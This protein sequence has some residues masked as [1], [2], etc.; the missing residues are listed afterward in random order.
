MKVKI[1]W[2]VFVS[3]LLTGCD[4]YSAPLSDIHANKNASMNPLTDINARLA[5][6]CV[7]ETIPAASTDTDMLFNYARWMQK[8]NL[9]CAGSLR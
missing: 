1:A 4:Q 7:H 5:F 9:R 6:T 3:L 2:V 8:N